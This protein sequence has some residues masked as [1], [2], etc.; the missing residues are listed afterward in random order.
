MKDIVKMQKDKTEWY[1]HLEY[2]VT[3]AIH[4]LEEVLKNASFFFKK[5]T[6]FVIRDSHFPF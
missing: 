2:P 5:E 3:F 4:F 6:W 1:V